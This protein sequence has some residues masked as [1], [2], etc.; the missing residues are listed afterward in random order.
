MIPKSISQVQTWA[1]CWRSVLNIE[2]IICQ[3]I[4]PTSSP[5]SVFVTFVFVIGININHIAQSKLKNDTLVFFCFVLFCFYQ[6]LLFNSVQSL[7]CVQL[8]ATP[9]TIACQAS[10]SIAISWNL[11]KLMS[12]ES[13]MPSNDLIL[14]HHLLLLPSILLSIRVFSK[15]SVL[16][17]R[18][19]KYWSFSF[20]NSPSNEYSGLISF[21]MDWFD[22]LALQGGL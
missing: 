10:L 8:F 19:P 12:I 2:K 3:S 6:L 17:I 9:W 15:E 4:N 7:S 20:S 22:L 11:F 1:E 16:R 13:V 14:C 18:W 5:K 21:R